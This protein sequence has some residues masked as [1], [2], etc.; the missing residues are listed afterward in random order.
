MYAHPH[1]GASGTITLDAP[2]E[3]VSDHEREEFH[4]AMKK[5]WGDAHEPGKASHGGA[6]RVG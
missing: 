3:T 5:I 2:Y 4:A 6:R 1:G